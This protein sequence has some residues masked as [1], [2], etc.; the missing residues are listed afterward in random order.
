M[1]QI[2][3][4]P[5]LSDNEVKK[6]EGTFFTKDLIK[7]HIKE[8]TKVLNENGDILCVYKKKVVPKDIL[9]KCRESFRKAAGQSNNR[10]LASGL[11][12][13]KYKVGDKIGGRTIGE[14]HGT[15]YVPINLKDKKL[16]KTSYALTVNSGIIGYSDRYPRIPYCR[17][18]MYNQRNF[19]DFLKCIPYIKCVDNFFKEYAPARYKIQR[20]MADKTAQDFVIKDTSFTTVTVNK[21]FRTAGHYDNGD[22]KEGFGNLG[23]ISKG[24]YDGGVTVIPR[25]G[26]GLNLQDGD[27]AIFDVHELHGNTKITRKG[28]YERISVVCYYRE[29]MIYC[30]N[31]EYELNRA[32]TNTKKVALPKEL[33]KAKKIKESILN[34]F[35]HSNS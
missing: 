9:N 33:D 24:K 1:K 10:G 18:T 32:K 30:G 11:I 28:Y 23:V 2:K 4:N 5:I 35:S 21:N 20:A 12:T 16:S 26:V 29:K 34:E 8:D 13:E 3:I 19:P 6:L 25:Y 14:I 7:Y 31:S 22:L 17:S 15:R 27:V